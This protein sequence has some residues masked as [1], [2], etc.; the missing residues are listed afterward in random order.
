MFIKLCLLS[1]V[2]KLSAYISYVLTWG[3]GQRPEE[4]QHP[5]PPLSRLDAEHQFSKSV[6]LYVFRCTRYRR[7]RSCQPLCRLAEVT[8]E[9]V[10]VHHW[11]LH[12]I[13]FWWHQGANP[14]SHT[15]KWCQRCNTG[16]VTMFPLR[17]MQCIGPS[18]APSMV[19]TIRSDTLLHQ[20][21][22]PPQLIK[23]RRLHSSFE[24]PPVS[25][26]IKFLTKRR[27]AT[28]PDKYRWPPLS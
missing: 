13:H 18:R 23:I 28:H 22:L 27:Q 14:P 24:N 12:A 5:P 3:V 9:L 20:R 6:V 26:L 8:E 2:A 16:A 19:L 17:P 21:L 25:P 10:V 7:C 15:P 11:S 1:F 4:D